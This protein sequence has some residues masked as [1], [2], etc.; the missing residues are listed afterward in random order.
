MLVQIFNCS[1][2]SFENL[3]FSL[4]NQNIYLR[5][6]RLRMWWY[7]EGRTVWDIQFGRRTGTGTWTWTVW[8][9]MSETARWNKVWND[10]YVLFWAQRKCESLSLGH[11]FQNDI[12]RTH[13]KYIQ[14]SLRREFNDARPFYDICQGPRSPVPAVGGTVIKKGLL[15]LRRSIGGQLR[16]KWWETHVLVWGTDSTRDCD[17][18]IKQ[19]ASSEKWPS[20]VLIRLINKIRSL[21]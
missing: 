8:C 9:Q 13:E 20:E 2:F 21:S 10:D 6:I 12:N 4:L 15:L 19:S 3:T 1:R 5:N 11:K 17:L 16:K 7:H 14:I 18:N